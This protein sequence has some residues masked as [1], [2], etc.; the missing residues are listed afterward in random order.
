MRIPDL[1]PEE[2]ALVAEH[3]PRVKL[4]FSIPQLEPIVKN[5]FMLRLLEDRRILLEPAALPPVATEIE[6]CEVWWDRL[7]GSG[8]TLGRGR[9]QAL[10]ELGKRAMRHPGR[11][12]LSEGITAEVLTSLESDRVLLRDADRD[13]YRFSH[14]LI[15]DWVFYRVLNQQRDD[16]AAYLRDI[17]QPLGLFRAIQLL[18]A[19]LLE[20]EET[21]VWMQLIAQLEEAIDLAPRWRQALLTAPLLSLR[22]RELLTRAEPLLVG[23]DARRLIDL[24]V[25]VRTVEVSPD[26]SL[27]PAAAVL[28]ESTDE[29]LPLLMTS[30]I[31]RWHVWLPFMGWLLE[32]IARL[33]TVV[34]PEIVKVM[35]IWQE[36]TP[37]GSVHRKEIGKIALSWLRELE[38]LD[39]PLYEEIEDDGYDSYPV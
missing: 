17:G 31:P 20:K 8:G 28:S 33:P 7:I 24:L 29:L 16:L 27:F 14:D 36:K 15:E 10:I 21:A 22:A 13:V 11:R 34:G 4:L 6:V 37:E 30:P 1:T 3:S 2:L 5:P 35:Q 38:G 39:R 12:L 32:H 18:G 19:S 23:G 9:Q 26:F 25:A